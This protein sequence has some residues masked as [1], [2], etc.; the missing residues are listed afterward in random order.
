MD[1]EYAPAPESAAIGAIKDRYLPYID[2]T[3]VEG[4]GEDLITYNPGTAEQ[5]ST[6][7]TVDEADIDRAVAAARRAYQQVWGPMSGA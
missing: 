4:G 5:L 6:V 1:W 3:F 2:G 7:S